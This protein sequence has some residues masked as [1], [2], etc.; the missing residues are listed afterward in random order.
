MQLDMW[1]AEL[2][3]E[4]VKAEVWEK[5]GLAILQFGNKWIGPEPTPEASLHDSLSTLSLVGLHD[6]EESIWSPKW[7]M[8]G[9]VDASVHANLV[10]APSRKQGK[11]AISEVAKG[12]NLGRPMPFE[13][14]TGRAVGVMEH[15]AQTMLYTLLMEERYREYGFGRRIQSLA[16]TMHRRYQDSFWSAILYADR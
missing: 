4:D 15:R 16:L 5:A 14:K 2:G 1:A 7:G 10:E 6:I 11:S 12:N 3:F 9:K 8:K 13:I